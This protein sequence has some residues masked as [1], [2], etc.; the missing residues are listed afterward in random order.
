MTQSFVLS[1]HDNHLSQMRELREEEL[2][3]VS[4][5][6]GGDEG[7]PEGEYPTVSTNPDPKLPPRPCDEV[8]S[9]YGP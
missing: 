7:C 5:G 8:P 6:D 2:G 4:G 9:S 1:L 3:L